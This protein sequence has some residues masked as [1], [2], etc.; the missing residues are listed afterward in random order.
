[1]Q[2][3]LFVLILFCNFYA[4]NAFANLP[5]IR[6]SETEKF[7]R[8]ISAPIFRAA[9]LNADDITF[10]IVNDNSINAF[11][12]AGQNIFVNTGL[13]RRFE[14]P[15]ALIGVIAHET[16]HIKGGHLARNSEGTKQA[17]GAMLLSYLLG[18]G[19]MIGGSAD[20]GTALIVGGSQTAQRLYM[21]YTRTQEEAADQYAIKFLDEMQYP[22][23]GLV[24]LLEVLDREMIGYKGKF[25]EYLLSHPVSRKRID[26]IKS[27][28]AN[29]P[30]SD[31]KINNKF[32]KRLDRILAKLEGFIEDPAYLLRK[33]QYPVSDNEKYVK[34]IALFRSSKAQDGLK[35]L[36]E[37]IKNN[38]GDGFLY[39]L[40]GQILFESGDVDSSILVYDKAIKLLSN[41]DSSL[42]RLSF[43]TAILSLKTSDKDLV[44]LAIKN[45]REARKLES[46]SPFLFK[47][48][49]NAYNKIGD[50]GRAF[51]A[52]AEY[53][54]L[55]GKYD[56]CQKYAQDAKEKL[57]KSDKEELLQADD[58]IDLAKEAK[59]KKSEK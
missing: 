13:I 59:K 8:D 5:L 25:D 43:A 48:L 15:D 32:Q 1:M 11:V 4:V 33:Y 18:I 40:K 21:R 9:D 58:L 16:G 54:L 50:D 52:L 2:R 44:N 51:L 28:T 39:E 19:A 47:Q 42:S 6:D 26:V 34:S 10:Y 22:A 20:A 55:T 56:K 3:F 41:R 45:L 17:E 53:N 35:L 24:A 36:D 46:H 57:A 12:A 49:A 27:R 31:K 23:D 30:F 37:V 29:R 38:L 14:T 7:L